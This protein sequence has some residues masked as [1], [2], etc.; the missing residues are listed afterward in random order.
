MQQKS[1]RNARFKTVICLIFNGNTHF[2][3][4]EI[5]GQITH[6]VKGNNGFGYDGVFMPDG[7]SITFAEMENKSKPI[8]GV[9]RFH[10]KE[11]RKII[12]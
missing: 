10:L 7:Y 2:F 1:N 5:K 11:I 6:A 3:E 4:G 8:L 12:I 9:V